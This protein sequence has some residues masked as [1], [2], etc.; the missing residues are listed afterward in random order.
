M[1]KKTF[2]CNQSIGRKIMGRYYNGDI[3]GK[4]WFGVQSSN[5]ADYFG[6]EG[7]SR[8]MDYYFEKEDAATVLKGISEC[9]KILGKNKQKL[10]DFFKDRESYDWEQLMPI[11]KTSTEG[12]VRDI[13]KW[14]ARLELGGQIYACIQEKG[15]CNF[16]AEM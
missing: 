11:L 13:L 9:K 2:N 8:V 3:E 12:K 10:D 15:E 16:E 7:H 1:G 5:D 6:V 4:F 14:Y